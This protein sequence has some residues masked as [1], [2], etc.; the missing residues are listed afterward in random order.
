MELT[1]PPAVTLG[2]DV[3]LECHYHLQVGQEH[4]PYTK[5]LNGLC[6]K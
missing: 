3:R 1:L 2:E 5:K 6:S 4:L